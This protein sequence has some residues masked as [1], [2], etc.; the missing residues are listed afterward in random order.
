MQTI[1]GECYH[2]LLI[3]L[4]KRDLLNGLEQCNFVFFSP[5][6]SVLLSIPSPLG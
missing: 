2:L 3:S 1:C 5:L 4:G 6:L